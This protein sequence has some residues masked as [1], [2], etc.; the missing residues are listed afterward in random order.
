MTLHEEAIL[1]T[2]AW[3]ND[4]EKKEIESDVYTTLVTLSDRCN[5]LG[6]LVDEYIE[7]RSNEPWQ[8]AEAAHERWR[9]QVQELEDKMQELS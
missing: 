7:L 8:L 6:D 1:H 2:L 9:N 5:E 3:G 4:D